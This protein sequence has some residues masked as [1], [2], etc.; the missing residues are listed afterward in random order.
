V[1]LGRYE[2]VSLRKR[3]EMKF[4]RRPQSIYRHHQYTDE[5]LSVSYEDRTISTGNKCLFNF[6]E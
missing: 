6:G 1:A 2:I 5:K 3:Y 4:S